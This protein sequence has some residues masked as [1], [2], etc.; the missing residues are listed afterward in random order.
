[1]REERG[2]GRGGEGGEGVREEGLKKLKNKSST[3]INC[4][5][6]DLKTKQMRGCCCRNNGNIFLPVSKYVR[7]HTQYMPTK[8]L[9][10]LQIPYL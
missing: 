6:E 9:A 3:S 2:W 4:T 5:A 1:M 8:D 7:V 10:M